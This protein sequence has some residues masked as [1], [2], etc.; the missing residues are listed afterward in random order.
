MGKM[1]KTSRIVLSFDDGRKDNYRAA[2]NILVPRGLKA[3]FNITTGYIQ[4]N[5]GK[6]LC[7]CPNPPMSVQEI[8]NLYKSDLFEI[9]GHGYAHMNTLVDWENGITDLKKWL[10]SEWDKY[11]I[12]IASPH[13]SITQREIVERKKEL[14]KLSV[15]YVRIGLK[16]QTNFYQRLVSKAA[17]K[18]RSKVLF[19]HPIKTSLAKIGKDRC[20][21]SIPILHAHTLEQV[22]YL[23]DYAVAKNLDC[24]FMFHS[25]L[26][27]NMPY[28]EDMF[29][30][31]YERFTGLCEYLVCLR[32]KGQIK[33]IR[34]IDLFHSR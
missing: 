27:W 21:Y 6:D 2:C 30:W 29:S 25:I 32:D 11:G 10:G 26:E 7:P 20:V 18:T 9:A 33:N 4:G 23:V 8:R 28:Y 24:I 17:M 14:E 15:R 5:I 19:I 16:N 1:E 34:N 12:G 13:C 22:I 31:D 3:T